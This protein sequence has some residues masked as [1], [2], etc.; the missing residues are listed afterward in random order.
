[1]DNEILKTAR[2]REVFMRSFPQSSYIC[3]KLLGSPKNADE[4]LY[5]LYR[6]VLN[7]EEKFESI[8]EHSDWI[9]NA[10]AVAAAAALRKADNAI[11]TRSSNLISPKPP[12]IPEGSNF[13]MS[14]TAKVVDVIFDSMNLAVRT[15]AIFYYYNGM[16][17]TQ[18]AKVMDIPEYMASR[19]LSVADEAIGAL[20]REIADKKVH[21]TAIIIPELLDVVTVSLRKT[22]SIDMSR[23]APWENDEGEINEIAPTPKRN[24]VVIILS[25]A[26]LILAAIVFILYGKLGDT[27][28]GNSSESSNKTYQLTSED[29][30]GFESEDSSK[31]A[32]KATEPQYYIIEKTV[33]NANG[34]TEKQEKTLYQGGRKTQVYTATPIFTEN[35]KYVWNDTKNSCTLYN[36]DN[37]VIE[38]TYYDKN[39]NPKEVVFA[40]KKSQKITWKYAYN[41]KGLI[42]KAMFKGESVGIYTYKY[43]QHNNIIEESLKKDG[44]TYR[45]S[46][47][48]DDNFMVVEKTYTDFDGKNTVYYY[49]YNYDELT[50]KCV[51]SDGSRETGK[52]RE[53]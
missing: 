41:E 38:T 45:T 28:K 13:N 26:V 51:C 53:K 6:R 5:D 15:A 19:L 35:I 18:I 47:K 39:G 11:F 8:K 49:T 23:L 46:Y 34:D 52:L 24:K 16:S 43:D 50:Y 25:A 33:I 12:R 10:A 3:L 2:L 42:K 27:T 21:T 9:K 29:M 20:K 44:D 14:E 48:Y 31:V 7:S 36:N 1:M 30:Q 4:V 22:S 17:I 40:D 32:V 37:E